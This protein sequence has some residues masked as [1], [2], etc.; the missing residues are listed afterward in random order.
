MSEADGAR[1]QLDRY[2]R[3]GILGERM[4]FEDARL[5][6]GILAGANLV[7][8]FPNGVASFLTT[9]P[10]ASKPYWVDPMTHAF[11]QDTGSIR[12]RMKSGE[13][14]LR[15]TIVK[16]AARL[17]SPFQEHVGRRP[18]KAAD[19]SEQ[20]VMT[21]CA[22][23]VMAFQVSWLDET[24]NDESVRRYI[25][26][27]ERTPAFLV[28][29]YFHVPFGRE[30]EWAKLNCD[31]AA[32]AAERARGA[33]IPVMALLCLSRD[34]LCS[35]GIDGIVSQYGQ[36]PV[37]AVGLWVA[38]LDES[39]MSLQEAQRLRQIVHGLSTAPGGGGRQ[40]L[41][42]YAGYYSM[43]LAHDG[44]TGVT[45]GPGY[46]EERDVAPVGGGWPVPKFY[47]PHLH[48][49]MDPLQAGRI[50]PPTA[51]EYYKSVCDC[52]TCR[53][54][55][56]DKIDNFERAYLKLKPS[57]TSGKMM[58]DPEA[59]R[60]HALHFLRARDEERRVILVSSRAELARRLREAAEAYARHLGDAAVQYLR[61]WASSIESAPV[62]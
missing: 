37:D 55:I 49:R 6:E 59:R 7:V 9:G 15:E 10:R 28:A 27:Q 19:F 33:G 13:E 39:R 18:L 23:R 60:T 56:G 62:G 25:D 20:S 42:V 41:R 38:A 47:H 32:L 22:D 17:G 14:K 31:L 4:F 21:A 58:V 52:E 5:Y 2:L 34:L 53:E 1:L 12:K 51:A 11:A 16:L 3:V 24:L 61:V 35:E 43:L 57:A 46:G 50:R 45:Y 36:L 26:P 48:V 44:V 29:P 40:V 30:D 8:G 54:A